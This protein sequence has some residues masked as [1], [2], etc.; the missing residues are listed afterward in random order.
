M[1]LAEVLEVQVHD[2][3]KRKP[4]ENVARNEQPGM[5]FSAYPEVLAKLR[6]DSPGL[7]CLRA[8]YS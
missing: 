7:D 8:C 4:P 1:F 5:F 3:A 2:K 6:E